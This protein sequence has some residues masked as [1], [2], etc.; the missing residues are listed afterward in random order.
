MENEKGLDRRNTG[1]KAAHLRG[2]IFVMPAE[3]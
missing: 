1:G 2:G 3:E